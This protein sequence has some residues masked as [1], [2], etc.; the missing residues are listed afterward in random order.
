MKFGVA[1]WNIYI[2][3]FLFLNTLES[4]EVERFGIFYGHLVFFTC[5]PLVYSMDIWYILTAIWYIQWPFDI[6]SAVLVC[7]ARKIWQ[8]C[9][10]S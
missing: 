5:A 9:Y 2:P 4:L 8:P 7:R 6:F 3:K 10:E 1:R